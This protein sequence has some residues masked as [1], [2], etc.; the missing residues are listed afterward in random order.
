MTGLRVRCPGVGLLCLLLQGTSLTVFAPTGQ[1][2][3]D[4]M[5]NL[6]TNRW[7]FKPESAVSQPIGQR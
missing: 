7:A 4:R 3:P 1:Y 6:G 5:I 2:V